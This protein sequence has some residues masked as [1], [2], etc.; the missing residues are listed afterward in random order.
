[1]FKINTR[2]ASTS[3]LHLHFKVTCV[4]KIVRV[5]ETVYS[6]DW[7]HSTPSWALPPDLHVL[8]GV[9]AAN[10]SQ[11]FLQ[12]PGLDPD[13]CL[14]VRPLRVCHSIDHIFYFFILQL[15]YFLYRPL[16][17]PLDLCLFKSVNLFKMLLGM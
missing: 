3:I 6:I 13:Q 11:D 15:C 7:K 16:A 1:M 9:N 17:G 12:Q 14:P 4:F 10:K 8:H 5:L 2:P